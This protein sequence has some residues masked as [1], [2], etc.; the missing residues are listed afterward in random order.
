MVVYLVVA[1]TMTIAAKSAGNALVIIGT[2]ELPRKALLLHLTSY[3]Q[4]LH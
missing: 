2:F 4:R 1:V 3:K